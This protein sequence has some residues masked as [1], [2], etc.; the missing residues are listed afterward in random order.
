MWRKHDQQ[1][2]YSGNLQNHRFV[3]NPGIQLCLN[4]DIGEIDRLAVAIN[5]FGKEQ[6]LDRKTI[7][8]LNLIAEELVTNVIY[9]GFKEAEGIDRSIHASIGFA[10]S[11]NLTVIIE[12]GGTPFNPLEAPPPVVSDALETAQIGG[13]GIHLIRNKAKEFHYERIGSRNRTSVLIAAGSPDG[14]GV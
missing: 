6:C 1:R 2:T 8:D 3:S 13:L 7:F 11:N 12:D 14:G 9:H 4:D 5:A 10:D